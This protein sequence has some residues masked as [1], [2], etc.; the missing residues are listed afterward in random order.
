ME[1][2]LP[3][4]ARDNIRCGFRPTIKRWQ[5]S[6]AWPTWVKQAYGAALPGSSRT[7]RSALGKLRESRP[8]AETTPAGAVRGSGCQVAGRERA[9]AGDQVPALLRR[10]TLSLDY[11][12]PDSRSPLS[13][14]CYLGLLRKAWRGGFLEAQHEQRR[15]LF[16]RN[17]QRSPSNGAPGPPWPT[18]RH[19]LLSLLLCFT[20]TWILTHFRRRSALTAKR[21]QG[22][23]ALDLRAGLRG[24]SFILPIR[25]EPS[26]ATQR[27][28]AAAVA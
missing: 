28:A 9:G 24:L 2:A 1:T 12:S 7:R 21:S 3:D 20:A 6:R 22:R 19:S 8:N 13:N 4:E 15:Q 17:R 25:A 26:P 16:R 18:Y 10:S 23:A 11:V 5:T 27:L 14:S